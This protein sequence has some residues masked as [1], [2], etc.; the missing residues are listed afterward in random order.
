DRERM[1]AVGE[2]GIALGARTG[3][4]GG[5]VERALEGRRLV[6]GEGEARTR[7]LAGVRRLGRNRLLR[8]R[9][10]H[11]PGVALGGTEV[12]V[13]VARPDSECVAAVGESG[14][15]VGTRTGEEGGAVQAAVE[16]D[17]RLGIGEAERRARRI[18]RVCWGRVERRGGRRRCGDRRRIACWRAHVAGGGACLSVGRVVS[19]GEAPVV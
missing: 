10:V 3:G 2:L 17:A 14:V 6:G 1:A 16:G 12:A 18:A 9:R 13:W 7:A 19:C 15:A 4:E 5:A 8:R 11:R